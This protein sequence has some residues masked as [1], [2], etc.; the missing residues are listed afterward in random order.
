MVPISCRG[1]QEFFGILYVLIC[2]FGAYITFEDKNGG[3][4]GDPIKRRTKTFENL[5]D[6]KDKNSRFW[7][8][9][10]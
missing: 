8:G 1:A 5:A 2:F 4:L 7:I 6:K 9:H 10:P 3:I